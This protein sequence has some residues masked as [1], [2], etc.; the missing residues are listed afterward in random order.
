[1]SIFVVLLLSLAGNVLIYTGFAL[2]NGHLLPQQLRVVYG[3]TSPL[4]RTLAMELLFAVPA[5]YIFS[6][7]FTVV[8]APMIASAAI[9][10]TLVV[11][12]GDQ[13]SRHGERDDTSSVV[14]CKC[15]SGSL[16]LANGGDSPSA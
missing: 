8:S 3:V 2:I 16:P 13:S 6:R 12:M 9:L 15:D 11:V 1:M 5:N 10:G 14:R 4:Q 7:T